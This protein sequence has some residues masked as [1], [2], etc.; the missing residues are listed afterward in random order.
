MPVLS[1]AEVNSVSTTPS[2]GNTTVIEP[3]VSE[4]VEPVEMTVASA[5]SIASVGEP[6]EPTVISTSSMTAAT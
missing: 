2:R 5:T 6:V 1:I 3:V 4:L